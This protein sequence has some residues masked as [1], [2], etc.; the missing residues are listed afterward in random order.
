MHE[1]I[2]AR[3]TTSLIKALHH[4]VKR[5]AQLNTAINPMVINEDL[6][7][8][9]INYM[10]QPKPSSSNDQI[11]RLAFPTSFKD[12]T[13]WRAFRDVFLNYLHSI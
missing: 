12:Q 6:L 1:T 9:E 3:L 7:A 11:S 13:K 2:F 10:E 5:M 8:I 4:Y